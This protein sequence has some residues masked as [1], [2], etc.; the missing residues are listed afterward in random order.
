MGGGGGLGLGGLGVDVAWRGG[1]ALSAYAATTEVPPPPALPRPSTPPPP[2]ASVG[3]VVKVI[4]LAGDDLRD[5]RA[6]SMVSF[7]KC[8]LVPDPQV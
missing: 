5:W 8:D 2:P 7:H 3:E 6:Q 4:T 1:G